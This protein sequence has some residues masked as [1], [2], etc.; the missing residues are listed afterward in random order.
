MQRRSLL[1]LVMLPVAAGGLSGCQ[2]LAPESIR[3]SRA[4][5]D[6]LLARQFPLEKRVLEVIDLRVQNPAVELE[7][8]R[9]RL[10]SAFD[11]VAEDR[12]FGGHADAHL[13]LDAALRYEPSD[14]SLRLHDVRVQDFQMATGASP[15]HGQAQRLGALA[16]ERLLENLA[17]WRMKPEQAQRLDRLGVEP[18]AI[19]VRADA[20]EVA[21]G[22]IGSPGR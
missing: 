16:A 6:A 15:L 11:L 13:R 10:A 17:L 12:L 9:N 8:E 7:P 2:V 18:K 3:F 1:S 22:P 5:L 14:R 4:E 21:L 20:V 19:T